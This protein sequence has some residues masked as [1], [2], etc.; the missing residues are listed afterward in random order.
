MR[1]SHYGSIVVFLVFLLVSP[2]SGP[3]PNL[4]TATSNVE[5]ASVDVIHLVDDTEL[6]NPPPVLINGSYGGF[7]STHHPTDPSH[8]SL[9]WSHVA[10]TPLEFNANPDENEPDCW[11]FIYF[12]QQFTWD[13]NTLPADVLMRM[14]YGVEFSGDFVDDDFLKLGFKVIVWF[15]DSSGDW[16][17]T[18]RS[19]PPYTETSMSFRYDSNWFDIQDIF[20]GMIEVDGSQADPSD[21]VTVAVALVPTLRFES[22][23]SP[24]ATFSTPWQDATGGVTVNFHFLDVVAF[25]RDE[26]IWG[27]ERPL[28][29]GSWVSEYRGFVEDMDV[30]D[31]GSAYLI[32]RTIDYDA[33][34]Y[35][36]VLIKW[37]SNAQPLWTRSWSASYRATGYGIEVD[38]NDIYTVGV[39]YS[40]EG[41]NDVLIAKWD[42][43]G[44]LLWNRT[45]DESGDERGWDVAVAPDDYVYAVGYSYKNMTYLHNEFTGWHPFLLKYSPGGDLEWNITCGYEYHGTPWRVRV[46]DDGFIYTLSDYLIKW[47]SNGVQVWNI[48]VYQMRDFDIASDGS[49]IAIGVDVTTHYWSEGILWKYSSSGV[50]QWN[51]CIP[52]VYDSEYY[53]IAEGIT[54]AIASDD[55]VRAI[56]SVSRLANERL[57]IS[58]DSSG[59]QIS[60]QSLGAWYGY[61]G[62]FTAIAVGPSDLTY[63]A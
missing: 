12:T 48:S 27:D 56:V 55:S 23:P 15:V 11:D 20:A 34:V 44:S 52:V 25:M 58:F 39:E 33:G 32:G 59:N 50:E 22:E 53:D 60:N 9:M 30:S 46:G 19:F 29:N 26:N 1:P 47:N 51:Q 40:P 63:V 31:D 45:W 28:A 54:L 14:E 7:S 6:S 42:S 41:D 18:F 24:M 17:Y 61:A 57:L 3:S 10:G 8:I 43:S 16:T 5:P 62:D 4:V 21:T 38:G 37:G 13:Y 2:V 35:D 36:Q 49:I